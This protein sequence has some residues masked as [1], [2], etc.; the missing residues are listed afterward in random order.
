MRDNP[1]QFDA[2][3]GGGLILLP[4][5]SW[6]LT[7]NAGLQARLQMQS[8]RN[9]ASRDWGAK[10]KGEDTDALIAKLMTSSSKCRRLKVR[11]AFSPS[12]TAG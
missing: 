11:R 4:V 7:A 6:K 12:W 5:Q 8:R 2:A 9:Q 3:L 1:D 10:I